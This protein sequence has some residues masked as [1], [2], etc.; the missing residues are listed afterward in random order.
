MVRKLHT[1][2]ALLT[3]ANFTVYGLV[4][5]TAA[6]VP[7]WGGSTVSYRPFTR[8]AGET[9]R[10]VAERAVTLLGLSLATPVQSAVIQHPAGQGLVLDFWHANGRHTVTVLESEGRIRIERKPNTFRAYLSTLH[11]TTAAFHSGDWRMQLWADYNEFAMWGFVVMMASGAGLW[12]TSR[13]RPVMRRVHRWLAIAALPFL[14]FYAVTAVQM[15]HRRWL[16]WPWLRALSRSHHSP[17]LGLMGAVFLLLG[18]S[19]LY[20]WLESRA[21]RRTG[22]ILLG[23]TMALTVALVWSMRLG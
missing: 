11:A 3:F 21:Q 13:A 14:V 12:F 15:A 2:A 20:L 5:L 19:G 9:D 10:R 6:F 7:R 17:A 8:A 18:V 1:C 4:G 22:A 23:A 16:G